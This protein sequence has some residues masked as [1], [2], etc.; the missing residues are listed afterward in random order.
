MTRVYQ[1]K[2]SNA[3]S[4]ANKTTRQKARTLPDQ[5]R[6]KKGKNILP[7]KIEFDDHVL[8]IF[9]HTGDAE[10]VN[11]RNI[12]YIRKRYPNYSNRSGTV[13]T[14]GRQKQNNHEAVSRQ[15]KLAQEVWPESWQKEKKKLKR[16]FKHSD[17]LLSTLR[18]EHNAHANSMRKDS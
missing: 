3:H 11:Q 9:S 15:T 10:S 1:T 13:Y 4:S 7:K 8:D 18:E 17:E 12:E 16:W 14:D 5:S 6:L 2:R